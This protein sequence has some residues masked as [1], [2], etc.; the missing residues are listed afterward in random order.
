M[1]TGDFALSFQKKFDQVSAEH[2]GEDEKKDN[3]YDFQKKKKDT[4]DGELLCSADEKLNDKEEND[5]KYD[6]GPKN[7]GTFSSR[8]FHSNPPAQEIKPSSSS[9][10]KSA[11]FS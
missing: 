4:G 3:E 1:S 7:P 11:I 6:D 10:M 8:N 2:K 5:Q 9:S